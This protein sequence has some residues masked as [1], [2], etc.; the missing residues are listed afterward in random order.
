MTLRAGLSPDD[1]IEGSRE[2]PTVIT[3]YGDFECP[4]CGEAYWELKRLLQTYG[5][6]VA[7]IWRHFPLTQLHPNAL[8]AAEASE[9]ASAQG[10][11]WELHDL[12][13]ENQEDLAREALFSYADEV[14]LELSRFAREMQAHKYQPRVE[15]DFMSG[16]RSG[17]AGTPGLFLNGER[18][19]RANLAQAIDVLLGGGRPSAP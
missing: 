3:E 13:F 8:A 14:G 1:H 17:V 5:T 19:E 9:A 11:F 12:M 18:V 16:V 4:S 7:L 15:R 10:V 2:A 6:E